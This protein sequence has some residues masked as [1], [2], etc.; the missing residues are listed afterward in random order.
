MDAT[1]TL[2]LAWALALAGCADQ[3]PAPVVQRTLTP[4]Q[5]ERADESNMHSA[6]MMSC[7]A[8]GNTPLE[9]EVRAQMLETCLTTKNFEP[10]RD[11]PPMSNTSQRS[12]FVPPITPPRTDCSWVGNNWEC[13][14]H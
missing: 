8:H 11:L 9:C 14:E 7:V 10:C 5:Q 6:S 3:P 4:E 13:V 2:I 12:T 1:R